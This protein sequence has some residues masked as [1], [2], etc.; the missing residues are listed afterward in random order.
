MF[1]H[2]GLIK[3]NESVYSSLWHTSIKI[4][5]LQYYSNWTYKNDHKDAIDEKET[6]AQAVALLWVLCESDENAIKCVNEQ[7]LV[8]ILTKYL[9]INSYDMY[10]VVVTMQ[11]LMTITEDNINAIMAIKSSIG[12]LQDILTKLTA[13]DAN[14][15]QFDIWFLKIASFA[16]LS[17]IC[18]SADVCKPIYINIFIK[19]LDEVLSIDNKQLLSNLVSILPH[20]K[21]AAS[22]S[23]R[24]KVTNSKMALH[25]QQLTLETLT[26]LSSDDND[27]DD[28][29]ADVDDSEEI[30][31]NSDP[32]DV[33]NTNENLRSFPMELV[34]AF[35][36]CNLIGKIWEKTV[37]VD[38]DS[39]EILSQTAEGKGMLNQFYILRCRA[40]LCLNNLLPNFDIDTLGGIDY[41]YR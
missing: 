20:E 23:K 24:K 37:Q 2:F 8:P 33:D 36:H 3:M 26:N 31:M 6:Y 19:T 11:C 9:D 41:L 10:I 32:M 21:N 27:E 14:S 12:I 38:S 17:S 22:S 5:G 29:N 18:T 1:E 15:K 30:D 35:N 28:E 25:T 39:Q 7:N 4:S 34:E 16:L 40:Y 13:E